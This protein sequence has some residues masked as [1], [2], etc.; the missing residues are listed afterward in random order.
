MAIAMP[1]VCW[2]YN[3]CV[4]CRDSARQSWDLSQNNINIRCV[5]VASTS[6]I[7][8]IAKAYVHALQGR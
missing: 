5:A 8:V 6:V 1:L 7:C 2:P 4:V 3:V